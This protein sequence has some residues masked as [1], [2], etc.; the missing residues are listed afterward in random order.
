[1]SG[2]GQ[3]VRIGTRV[4]DANGADLNAVTAHLDLTLPDGTTTVLDVLN[5]P[6]Q[7]GHYYVDYVPQLPGP[8]TYRW[9]FTQPAVALEGAFNVA[10]I[11]DVGIISLGDA[12][13][14][15]RI[16]ETRFDDDIADTIRRATELAEQ[17]SGEVLARRSFTETRSVTGWCSGVKLT[18]RP[19]MRPVLLERLHPSGAVIEAVAPPTIWTDETGIL[20]CGRPAVFMGLIRITYVAGYA[21]LPDAKLG[22]VEY[23]IQHLWANRGGASGRPRVG[24][25]ET[26]ASV[27]D[28]IATAIPLRVREQ[29]GPKAP[30]VG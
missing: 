22:A 20:R 16:T 24:G 23:L 6:A 21:V 14:L 4:T 13:T 10:A 9:I 2:V 3:V 5:P 27:G 7:T 11:G 19:V 15:L 12:R 26:G 8:F 28:E 29:L 1:M 17:E 30:M 25:G 18:H